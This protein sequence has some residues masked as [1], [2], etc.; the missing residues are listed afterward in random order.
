MTISCHVGV[1]ETI[2]VVTVACFDGVSPH[3]LYREAKIR[4]V[5]ANKCNDAGEI[6]HSWV[7]G[8]AGCVGCHG[9]GLGCL[10]QEFDLD[11]L[12]GGASSPEALA[13]VRQACSHGC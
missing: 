1:C 4:M 12:A 2:K 5:E 9:H 3:L 7:V 6:E 10:P 11:V 8:S 13:G